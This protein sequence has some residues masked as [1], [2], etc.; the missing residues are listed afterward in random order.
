MGWRLAHHEAGT[1][2][3]GP[4]DSGGGRLAGAA[5]ARGELDAG[6]ASGRH[7][8]PGRWWRSSPWGGSWSGGRRHRCAPPQS[9]GARKMGPVVTR[10]SELL[11]RPRCLSQPLVR[12]CLGVDSP[13][14]DHLQH[15][16]GGFLVGDV[17][18]VAGVGYNRAAG[19][20]LFLHGFQ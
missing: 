17:H 7:G 18:H 4:R 9:V 11:L 1:G 14:A 5:V 8:F 3:P 20:P 2:R 6:A 13:L 10:R 12:C 16:P 15:G 19:L